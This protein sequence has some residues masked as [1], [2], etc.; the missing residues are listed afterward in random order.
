MSYSR[1]SSFVNVDFDD[2]RAVE[3]GYTQHRE[4]LIEQGALLSDWYIF[5]NCS[6]GDNLDDQVLSIWSCKVSGTADYEYSDLKDIQSSGDW[7]RISG[8]S[9]SCDENKKFMVEC[10]EAFLEDCEEDYKLE[11]TE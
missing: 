6:S 11:A 10:V 2:K 9:L 4:E 7:P 1:W 3:I 5:H 8:Y